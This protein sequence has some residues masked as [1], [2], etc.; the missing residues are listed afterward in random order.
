[1]AGGGW[2]PDRA[3]GYAIDR[4]RDDDLK[5]RKWKRRG[6][7]GENAPL[8]SQ[9][10]KARAGFAAAEAA[11]TR[12]GDHEEV[13]ARTAAVRRPSSSGKYWVACVRHERCSTGLWILRVRALL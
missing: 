5:P 10:F 1:M 4:R 9:Y 12:P 6:V 8:N 7:T 13:C 11:G 2:H 3:H